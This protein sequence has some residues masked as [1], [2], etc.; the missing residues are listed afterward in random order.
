MSAVV[1]LAYVVNIVDIVDVVCKMSKYTSC[2]IYIL[3][4]NILLV[5]FE[6]DIVD[7]YQSFSSVLLFVVSVCNSCVY[8][9]FVRYS[10]RFFVRLCA[11]IGL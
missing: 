2:H 3:H 9:D 4:V 8:V 1:I 6:F 7:K 10:L 11:V 5:C